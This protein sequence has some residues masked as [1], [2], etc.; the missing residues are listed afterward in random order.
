MLLRWLKVSMHF[1]FSLFVALQ[2]T[3]CK[4]DQNGE[5]VPLDSENSENYTHPMNLKASIMDADLE[6][7]EE[8]VVACE[9]ENSHQICVEICHRPPGNPENG[10]TKVLP[11]K[12][13]L[14]HLDHGGKHQ[15][16][17]YFGPCED[18]VI[19][20]PDL[21]GDDSSQNGTDSGSDNDSTSGDD[22]SAGSD[23]STD[24]S[25]SGSTGGGG[26]NPDVPNWCEPIYEFDSDCDGY[27]D[28]TGDPIVMAL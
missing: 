28:T 23:S 18:D 20:G 21:N 9:D 2:I 7:V 24:D 25:S 26:V 4:V 15:D 10:Q 13:T 22:S 12:A 14:K 8:N 6:T 16:K 11:L 3:A 19:V 17:D 1:L 27:N 5:L